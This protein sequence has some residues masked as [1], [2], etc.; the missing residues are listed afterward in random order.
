MDETV[1]VPAGPPV[2][3]LAETLAARHGA[4]LAKVLPRCSYL[5]DEFA[6]RDRALVLAHGATVDVLPPFAGG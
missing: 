5:V 2:D 6:V 3:G 4:E 1:E